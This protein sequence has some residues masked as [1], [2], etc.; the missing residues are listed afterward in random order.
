MSEAIPQGALEGIKILDL[1]RTLP[2]PFCTLML[3]DLGAEVIKIQEARRR[4]N[5]LETL[6]PKSE[7]T[8]EDL[9]QGY[10]PHRAID[11]N[12]KGMALDLKTD[13][14]RAVF[15]KLVEKSDVVVVEFRPKVSNRLG[16]DYETL[17]KINPGLIYCAITAFGQD[18]PYADYPAH[19]ANVIAAAGILGITGTPDGQYV[20][21][22]VPLADLA[23]GGMNA[24]VGILTA[25]LARQRTG[26][27]QFVDISMM[28]G[29]VAM[30]L[31][32]H[33]MLYGVTGQSA[34]A[35]QRP[36]HVYRTKDG[37]YLC[38]AGGEPWFWERLCKA[39][40][41][42]K[43]IPFDQVVR[44]FSGFSAKR[45]EVIAQLT[46]KFLSKTRDEWLEILHKADTCVAPVHTSMDE[47]LNDPQVKHR[48]MMVELDDPILG[49]V[50]QPGVAIKLS[51]TPGQVR[52]FSPRH[53][54]HTREILA[55]LG[56]SE[57]MIQ[58]LKDKGCIV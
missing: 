23:G 8:T 17:K 14:A 42:E 4:R 52:M 29:A 24:A 46:E 25:L 51:E 5:S 40:D 41:L 34:K 55:G 38:F 20:L 32:R 12:K 6:I 44:P 50:R 36:S 35:G 57:D 15:Y 2:G 1:S 13:E 45:D 39:L 56:Y 48:Q 22:G 53:G 21:P 26:K 27:G 7:L 33:G 19:D 54:Q 47:V 49:K 58:G 28:D 30:L 31:A 11:R 43:L 37:K 18:G 9:K 10:T 16:I 3:A